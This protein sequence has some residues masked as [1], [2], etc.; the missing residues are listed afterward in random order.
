MKLCFINQLK[1]P[2][3]LDGLR[4]AN[5]VW[6]LCSYNS[7]HNPLQGIVSHPSCT[8]QETRAQ[9]VVSSPQVRQVRFPGP[10]SNPPCQTRVCILSLHSRAS[11]SSGL[12]AFS[13]WMS[14]CAPLPP[15]RTPC[16]PPRPPATQALR[17][18]FCSL[19][20][21]FYWCLCIWAV[22]HQVADASLNQHWDGNLLSHCKWMWQACQYNI[23]VLLLF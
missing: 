16:F 1:I 21:W 6:I 20:L 3:L 2:D 5:C 4:S 18:V 22:S 9:E 12:P 13:T 19:G 8:I 7:N 15:P 14:Q 17:N 23:F 10:G 11:L